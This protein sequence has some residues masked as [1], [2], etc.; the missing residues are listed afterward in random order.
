MAFSGSSNSR[1]AGHQGGRLARQRAESNAAT[2]LSCCPRRFDTCVTG[3]DDYN[4]E[5]SHLMEI[6]NLLN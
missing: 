5:F 2:Q 3:S 4:I 6:I 1:V